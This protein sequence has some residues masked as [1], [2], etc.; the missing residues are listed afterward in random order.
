MTSY[1]SNI[2]QPNG[3]LPFKLDKKE[4]IVEFKKWIKKIFQKNI[5]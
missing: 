1:E 5:A 2:I 3:M 4:A